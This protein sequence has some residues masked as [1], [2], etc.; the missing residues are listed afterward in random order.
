MRLVGFASILCGDYFWQ[1]FAGIGGD[2]LAGRRGTVLRSIIT[3]CH[4][5]SCL[6]FRGS[7]SLQEK[8]DKRNTH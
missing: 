1:H 5:D 6:S 2:S 8:F 4:I 7:S 3:F